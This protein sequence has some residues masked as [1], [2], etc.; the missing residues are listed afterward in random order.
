MVYVLQVIDVS[1]HGCLRVKKTLLSH[2]R[3]VL[4]VAAAARRYLVSGSEDFSAC[5]YSYR[6]ITADALKYV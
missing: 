4:A 6:S 3:P 2:T 5:V 1:E